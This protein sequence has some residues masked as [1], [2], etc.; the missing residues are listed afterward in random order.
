VP[1][2]ELAVNEIVNRLVRAEADFITERQNPKVHVSGH[3]SASDLLL[4]LELLRPGVFAPIHGEAR[5]QRAHAELAGALGISADRV[6]VLDNG[7]VLEVTRD[8]AA[9]IDRVHAGLSYVDQAGGGDITESVLRDRRHLAD[10]G[11]L[12][13]VAR[14][15]ASDGSPVGELEIVSRGFGSGDDEE[16]IEET[17]LAVERSLAAS[18]EQRVTEIGVLQHQL[19]DVVAALIRKRT[20]QRPVVVPVIL[21]V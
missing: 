4:M 19:H 3:G 14:V 21:E 10:D 9:I 17:R 2:N 16:L 8:D 20:Q 13:I 6:H 5:H 12:L 11:L 18:A 7:D 1:G 15:D